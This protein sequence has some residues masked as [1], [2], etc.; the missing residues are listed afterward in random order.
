VFRKGREVESWVVFWCGLCGRIRLAPCGP[1]GE[2]ECVGS[3]SGTIRC[4]R[5][6]TGEVS[7]KVIIYIYIFYYYSI[8]S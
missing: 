3:T 7:L 8:R 6:R 4:S 2:H 5:T 1:I